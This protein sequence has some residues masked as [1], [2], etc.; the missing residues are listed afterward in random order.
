[1]KTPSDSGPRREA[2]RR[3]PLSHKRKP[4]VAFIRPGIPVVP[5]C[6]ALPHLVAAAQILERFVDGDPE[7]KELRTKLNA[8]IDRV[9]ETTKLP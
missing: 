6:A 8:I 3:E 9:N 2:R 5:G 1:M 7:V 4:E